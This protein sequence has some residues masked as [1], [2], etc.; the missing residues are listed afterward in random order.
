MGAGVTGGHQT[1]LQQVGRIGEGIGHGL[2]EARGRER[3]VDLAREQLV[4]GQRAHAVGARRE[5]RRNEVHAPQAQDLL[6]QVDLALQVGA[7]RGCRDLQ[8]V[9]IAFLDL[10]VEAL[11]DVDDVGTRHVDA[12]HLAEARDAELQLDGRG[13]RGVDVDDAGAHAAARHLGEQRRGGRGVVGDGVV[14][15][16]ALVAHGR[17]AD[18]AQVA[19]RTA[20]AAVLERR[21]LQQHC[22]GL[23][24]DLGVEAAH[25]A[26]ERH[27]A[28]GRGDDGHVARQRAVHLV[29]RRELLAVRSSAHDDVRLAVAADQLVVVECV[30]RLAVQEQDIVGDIHHVVDGTG[31]CRGHALGEPLRA[32]ADLHVLDDARRVAGAALGILDLDRRQVGDVRQAGVLLQLVERERHVF[33]IHRAHLARHA[34][35]AQAVGAVRRDLEVE[36]RVAH[37]HIVGEGHANGSILRQNHDAVVVAADAEL[38]RRTVHAHA[39]D[40][41]QLRLLDGEIARQGG[42]DERRDDV[43]PRVEVLRAAH[44]LQRLGVAVGVHVVGAHVHLR[45]PHVVGVGVRLLLEHL[46]GDDLVERGAR[47]LDALDARAREVEPIAE[48]LQVARHVNVFVKP[49]QTNFHIALSFFGHAPFGRG[50]AG[51][52]PTGSPD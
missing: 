39:R 14:V 41:A 24:G 38:A 46:G 51:R 28:L 52:A 4:I 15:H 40:A 8:D 30:E 35:H 6:V 48:R 19:A 2:V 34:H 22:G 44:D 49:I 36:H 1:Q 32:G 17:L 16:A 37:L 12:H 10:A 7:A 5:R 47:L 31:A 27:C 25:D 21:G 42:A 11:E 33:A 9:A 26:G 45:H 50:R 29:E 3:A 13:G 23:L 20:R 43:V 18:Q